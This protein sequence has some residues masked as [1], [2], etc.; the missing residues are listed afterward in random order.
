[1]LCTVTVIGQNKTYLLDDPE[2]VRDV[3]YQAGDVVI[4]K[5]GVYDTDERIIF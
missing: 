3:E 1:M 4:L 5:N 2:D